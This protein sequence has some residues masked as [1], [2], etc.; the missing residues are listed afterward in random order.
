[1]GIATVSAVLLKMSHQLL[2]GTCFVKLSVIITLEHLQECPLCPLVICGITGA[3]LTVP[4]ITETDLIQLL[5]VTCD[6]LVGGDF[7]M[8]TRLDGILLGRKTV[9]VITHG[10]QHIETTQAFVT[11]INIAGNIA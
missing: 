6:V 8:L 1:M 11:R 9:C 4:I 7:G 5:T 2:N 10:M 3:H